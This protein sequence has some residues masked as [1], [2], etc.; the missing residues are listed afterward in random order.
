MGIVFHRV[1]K[2]VQSLST[3]MTTKTIL[4]VSLAV[5]FTVSMIL[6]ASAITGLAN[7]SIRDNAKTYQKVIFTLDD[8]VVTDGTIFGGYAFFTTDGDVVA[9]TSHKGAY[10]SKGQKFDDPNTTFALCNPGQLSAGLCGPEWHTHVVKPVADPHCAIAAVGALTYEQPSS[11]VKIKDNTITLDNVKK[12]T[13]TFTNSI[14]SDPEEFIVGNSAVDPNPV[15]SSGIGVPFDLTPA[16]EGDTLAAVCIGP[17][18][19]SEE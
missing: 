13:R 14:T 17:L 5:I 19:E 11:H 9:V 15:T 10:D 8:S 16:F 6:S 3:V 1:F 18:A 7:T 4:S 12:G 2:I